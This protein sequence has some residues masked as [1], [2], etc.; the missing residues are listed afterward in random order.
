M[1]TKNKGGRIKKENSLQ[2]LQIK[3]Y[4]DRCRFC[5]NSLQ[6]IYSGT[7]NKYDSLYYCDDFCKEEYFFRKDL[8]NYFLKRVNNIE[9]D[10]FKDVFFRKDKVYKKELLNSFNHVD[11][12][13]KY[14]KRKGI[15]II[16]K[17]DNNGLYYEKRK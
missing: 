15:E 16:N 11:T 10:F 2:K 17:K 3:R 5:Q 13:L 8:Q 1:D 6:K 4:V 9:Y 14:L 12:Y 7:L